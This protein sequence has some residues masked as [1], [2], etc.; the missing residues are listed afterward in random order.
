MSQR[1]K[2]RTKEKRNPLKRSASRNK[3]VKRSRKNRKTSSEERR[4]VEII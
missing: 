4:I 2:R 3:K 1:N